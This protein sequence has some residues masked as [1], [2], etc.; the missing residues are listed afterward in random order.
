MIVVGVEPAAGNDHQ[1]SREAGHIV[2]LPEVPRTIADGQQT[3]APGTL[4]WSVNNVRADIF[5]TVSDDEIVET[6]KLLFL[7]HK[8]VVEP[9]GA[10]ALAAA[11]HRGM[12]EPGMRVGV[13]LSG[14]NIDLATFAKLTS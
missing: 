12:V 8:L 11:L 13:T 4:T 5:T 7:H 3:V 6:M 9:S 2:T 1:L 10:T 14:G